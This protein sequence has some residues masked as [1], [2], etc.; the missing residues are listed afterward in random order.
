MIINRALIREVV[1]TSGAVTVVIVSIFLVVRV[2]GFLKEA[3]QGDIPVESVL[4][5]VFL[6]LI[7]YLDVII[8]LML[9]IAILMVLGRWNRDNEMT[10][11]AACGIGLGNFLRPLAV[12]AASTAALV[13]LF[14]FY[15]GPLSVRAGHAIE[16]EFKQRSEISG[17]IPGVFMETRSGGGVYFVERYDRDAGRY[18]NVFVYKSSFNKEGVVVAKYGF[19]RVDELTGDPF[20]ILRNGTRYEGNPGEPNYR[21][22]DFETYA[23]RIEQRNRRSTALPVKGRPMAEL[24][25]SDHPQLVSEW[26]WRISKVIV[27]PILALFALVFS[28]VNPR[29]GRMFGM[30][31]AFLTYFLYSNVLGF[32]VALMKKGKLEGGWGL[33]AIHA[34]FLLVALYFLMRRSR[35]LPFLPLPGRRLR[36]PAA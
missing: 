24:I 36:A 12:L 4:V 33:L 15:L 17:V 19:Q 35:N 31:L 2:L 25:R 28:H 18:E 26:N 21:I 10:V 8:P 11:L 32:G 14:S 27:V 23:L 29:E 22:L 6:K 20:L 7:S 13:A 1:Y 5:L 3:A 16:Q 30:I 34:V 9:Y